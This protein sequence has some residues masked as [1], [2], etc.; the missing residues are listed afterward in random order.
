MSAVTRLAPVNAAPATP[1]HVA[2]MT[3]AAVDHIG[4]T[5]AASIDNAADAI[6]KE[7][8]KL[9][10]RL[11]K[12]A[13]AMREHTRLAAQEVSNFSLMMTTMGDTVRGLENQITGQVEH[14]SSADLLP[15]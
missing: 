6:E 3:V 10:D 12:L 7:G 8:E 9:A 2:E 4:N 15:K 1:E 13:S 5:S 14:G 11:R